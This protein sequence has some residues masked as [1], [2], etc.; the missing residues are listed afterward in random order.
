MS[1]FAQLDYTYDDLNRPGAAVNLLAER[2]AN[3]GAISTTVRSDM[4]TP[5]PE[6]QNVE[7][8][9]AS[10]AALKVS[11]IGTQTTVRLQPEVRQQLIASLK[12]AAVTSPPDRV[13]LNL[14]NV[15]GAHDAHVLN[16]FINLPPNSKPAE[17]P[18]LL[19][20]SVAL[21]GIRDASFELGEHG[22]QG[23][24]FALDISKV[25]DTLHLRNTLD[26]DSLDVTI[27]PN[28]L[29]ADQD[30]ITI[31]RISVFRKGR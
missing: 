27:V 16:V 22:G 29:V 7:L 4:T 10:P 14:E 8:I 11:G 19:A 5:V 12:N 23:L 6:G 1:D 2:L 17:H 3:L 15:R 9:G 18:E 25:V 13:I 26:S 28:K 31:G 20:G 21:F 30:Q 24:N